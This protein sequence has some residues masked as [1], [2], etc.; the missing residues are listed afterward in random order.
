VDARV[1]L[2][3]VRTQTLIT[4]TVLVGVWVVAAQS[5]VGNAVL[6]HE[7]VGPLEDSTGEGIVTDS[8][9]LGAVDQTEL[10]PGEL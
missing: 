10:S 7:N 6:T 3:A 1:V 4:F 5:V 9:V 8:L 2:V